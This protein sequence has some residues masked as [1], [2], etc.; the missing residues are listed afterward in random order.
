MAHQNESKKVVAI[1]AENLYE[2][3][4]KAAYHAVR[5]QFKQSPTETNRNLI[6]GFAYL[7][8]AHND[9]NDIIQ[10]AAVVLWEHRD[11][12]SAFIEACSA[13]S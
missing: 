10:V 6:N 5:M 3:A 1:T 4:S 13:V 8:E 9:T 12:E 11:E 7:Q 2:I